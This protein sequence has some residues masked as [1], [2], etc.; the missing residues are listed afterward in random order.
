MI[1]HS[2]TGSQTPASVLATAGDDWR[3]CAADLLRWLVANDRCFSSG[4]LAHYIRKHRPD[5]VFSVTTLGD[6]LRDWYYGQELPSYTEDN[7][8][9]LYPAMVPRTTQ[10]TFNTAAGVQVFVY[11]KN[12]AEGLQHDFEV[13]VPTPRPLIPR[14]TVKRTTE[15]LTAHVRSDRRCIVPRAAFEFFVHEVGRTIRIGVDQAH[16]TFY[17]QEVRIT[18]DPTPI[19]T[20]Y[21]LWAGRG[22]IAFAAPDGQ[23]PYMPGARFAVTVSPTR[24]TIHTG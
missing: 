24:L 13:S 3:T 11:A 1:I 23:D 16:L 4:E 15:D 7:G 9:K 8:D 19:S 17:P 22:R 12:E 21:H 2:P 14:Q 6:T 10:G 20:P 5:V 18:L